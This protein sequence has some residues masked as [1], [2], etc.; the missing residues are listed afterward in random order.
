LGIEFLQVPGVTHSKQMLLVVFGGCVVA[1]LFVGCSSRS[2]ADS[3]IAAVNKTNIQRLANLY[4]TYQSLHEWHGPKDEA[5][6]KTFLH[7]FNA[8]MLSRI[9][10]D[11]TA[12]EPLFISERDGQ[13]FKIRYGVQGSSMGSSAPV[14]FE[15]VGDGKRRL[16]GFLDMQQ[17]EVDEAEYNSLWSSTT[18]APAPRQGIR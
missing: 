10:V 6:F 4:L 12:L 9:G 17:R 1:G 2:D 18:A 13:P 5:Q 7:S 14:I 16:V 3:A 11:P 8:H 15:S